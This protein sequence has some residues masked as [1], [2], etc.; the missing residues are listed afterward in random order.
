MTVRTASSVVR[1]CFTGLL[2]SSV[3]ML[4]LQG[5]SISQA[6]SQ[7]CENLCLQQTTCPDDKTTSISGTVYAPN[8]VDP[9]PD[10]LV[11]IPNAPVDAFTPG[12]ACMK[13]GEPASGSP[14]VSTTTAVDG[15][16]TL[17]NAPAGGDIPLVIQAGRWRR[18]NVISYVTA[19]ENTAVDKTLTRFPRNKTEGD[20]PKIAVVT[21]DVDALECV[22]RKFGIQDS[23][24]TG[25]SGTGRIH[26]YVG[27]NRGGAH[28]DGVSPPESQLFAPGT[29]NNYD[30][31]MFACQGYG[32]NSTVTSTTR[33]LLGNYANAGG[34]I[35][36][37][38]Y[39]YLWLYN[40]VLSPPTNPL[41]PNTV[42]WSPN[43]SIPPNQIGFVNTS[44]P[45]GQSLAQWLKLVNASSTLGQIDLSVLRKDQNGVI[46]PTQSWLTIN[47]PPEVVQFTFNT[48]VGKVPTE[49]CGR[50]MFNEYHVEDVG[51]N[52]SYG[53]MFPSECSAGPMTDQE[54]MLEFSLFDLSTFVSPDVPSTVTVIIT[55]NPA[56]FVLGDTADAFTIN[57]TN[58]ST[59]TATNP[60]LTLTAVLPSDLVV[61]TMAGANPDTG[62]IC[63]A[64]T[65]TCTRTT[66][67][68]AG[69]S[70]PITLTV[71]VSSG[72][73][74]GPEVLTVTATA[75]GG[76]IESDVTG[77]DSVTVQGRLIVAADNLN[78]TQG[79]PLP[80]LAYAITGFVGSDTQSSATTGEPDLSTT[81]TPDSPPGT[82]PIVISQGTLAAENYIFSFVDGVLSLAAD[83]CF[84]VTCTAL[85]QCHDVGVCDHAT[86]AC[87]SPAR[88]DGTGCNDDN[89]NTVGDVCTGGVCAGVD[90]CIGVI[91]S[92][93][94][95]CHEAGV[96]DHATGIC[97][98]PASTDGTACS[99]G[100]ACTQTD[101]CQAGVCR[102]LNFAWTG[103]LQPIN[104]DGT[105]IFK[106]G[107]T[108][109][110]K[111]KL[112]NPCVPPGTL[113]AKI[114]L[115]KVTN[116]ILGMEVEPT[117][118]SAADTG[119]TFRHD[120]SG[121]QYIYNLATKSFTNGNM[122]P[123]SAGTWQIRI[124]QYAGDIELVTIGTV[125]ISLR[126]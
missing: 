126:Q 115:A 80:P 21:G 85:D 29:L 124:A 122:T 44:F 53:K 10:V 22:L 25:P 95:Q 118:T 96:C 83:P 125:N 93:L 32:S 91:C 106:L 38:H 24:F 47:S 81:A 97:S 107:S 75:S 84:G 110:V 82:Y 100:N 42:Q 31:V 30:M 87:S 92:A 86:G 51:G 105:S 15:T 112:T 34:R 90:Y 11:Y 35:F 104:G 9:M 98:N 89:A 7:T 72:A 59:T 78:G 56:T 33:Q 64:G 49:Q 54:K 3:C 99:D 65:L 23:E 76:G 69:A 17:T 77:Q 37:T 50:V 1:E 43:Q 67:L 66:G 68:A 113:S 94:D 40:P 12:V 13:S 19:C 74:I 26:L 36:A 18:Q 14:L 8:G 52:P 108:V 120:A 57:V 109:P 88:V 45:K 39:S 20:I 73:P 2:V 16:F 62:W 117:S 58:T 111:F 101:T 114:F 63:T 4:L 27:T 46:S 102:S 123:L 70:D 41:F 55:N 60:S 79:Q 48:P 6:L 103:V 71:A 61:G 116:S 28:F 5:W 119:N 121:D